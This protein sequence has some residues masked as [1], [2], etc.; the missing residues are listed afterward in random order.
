[1][2]GLLAWPGRELVFRGQD[3]FDMLTG[4]THIKVSFEE[5]EGAAAVEAKAY[6]AASYLPFETIGSRAT[7]R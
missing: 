3:T 6:P 2:D 4:I 7:L 1:M 5:R